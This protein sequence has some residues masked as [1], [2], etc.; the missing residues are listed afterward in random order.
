MN[1]ER[2]S[3][4]PK[5]LRC[6]R[7]ILTI[8][9]DSNQRSIG[10]ESFQNCDGVP[11]KADRAIDGD[12]AVTRPKHGKDFV[13]HH[14]SMLTGMRAPEWRAL[15]FHAMPLSFRLHLVD[16]PNCTGGPPT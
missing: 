6:R 4:G 7:Q 8:Q 16:Y 3:D 12:L 2:T 9:I 10:Q 5:A 13:K 15:A 14:G 11:G 1:S